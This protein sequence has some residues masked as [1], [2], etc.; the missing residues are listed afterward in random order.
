MLHWE[1]IERGSRPARITVICLLLVAAAGCT[2]IGQYLWAEFVPRV[3]IYPGAVDIENDPHYPIDSH[4]AQMELWIYGYQLAFRTPDPATAVAA[5]YQTALSNAGWEPEQ[6]VIVSNDRASLIFYR[7]QH[8]TDTRE[9]LVMF[10]DREFEHPG[11][12][13]MVSII[14]GDFATMRQQYPP[15]RL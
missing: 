7:Q 10:A 3:P 6:I 5:F 8:D 9:R 4:G 2:I 15:L 1:G 13:I 14:I 11:A 12:K